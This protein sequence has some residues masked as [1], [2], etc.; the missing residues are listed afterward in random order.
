VGTGRQYG[1]IKGNLCF[2]NP[3]QL[4]RYFYQLRNN[5]ACACPDS[6][7]TQT[8]SVAA[9]AGNNS[10]QWSSFDQKGGL[11]KN[12]PFVFK[13]ISFTFVKKSINVK[14]NVVVKWVLN[15]VS[16]IV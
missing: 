5:N 2:S 8:C 3:N 9:T 1:C 6:L 13:S 12:Q 14:G 11:I 10:G 16:P 4:Y 7:D 15:S